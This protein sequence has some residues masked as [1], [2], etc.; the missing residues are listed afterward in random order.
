MPV[1]TGFW[2]WNVTRCEEGDVTKIVARAQKYRLGHVLVKTNDGTDAYNGTLGPL[3]QA[4]QDAR[5][6]V[7]AWAYVYGT[8]PEAEAEA[9]ADRATALGVSGLCVD[10][11]MEFK[12][13]PARA[14]AYMDRLKALVTQP[15][16]ISSYYLPKNHPTFPW[17]E[18]YGRAAWA[19]PQVYWYQTRPDVA[20]LRSMAQHE[21]YDIPVIPVGAAYQQATGDPTNVG[22]FLQ[23]ARKAGVGQANLWS[24][25]HATLMMWQ[26][27]LKFSEGE[28][29][30]T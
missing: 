21:T 20:L 16:A 23:T 24:W 15:I 3:V 6:N 25:E 10:A 29:A 2:I 19:M 1:S 9:F 12:G 28:T 13:Q 7:W 8:R 11:E 27:V 4:L 22:V 5:I 26:E 18:F 17:K 14:V 30:E